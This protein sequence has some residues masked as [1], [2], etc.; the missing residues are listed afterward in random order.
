[1]SVQTHTLILLSN[2]TTINVFVLFKCSNKAEIKVIWEEMILLSRV[3]FI[4]Y[5]CK[6]RDHIVTTAGILNLEKG[7]EV[8]PI[9][10]VFNGDFRAMLWDK[11]N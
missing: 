4:S 9:W 11:I 8:D 2:H 3:V 6:P 10:T 1:M 7:Y 5:E